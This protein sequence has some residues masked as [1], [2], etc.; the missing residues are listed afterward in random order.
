M[1][2]CVVLV[3]VVMVVVCVNTTWSWPHAKRIYKK[4]KREKR[5]NPPKRTNAL[6]FD[7]SVAL[8]VARNR[9]VASGN[10]PEVTNAHGCCDTA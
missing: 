4:T 9:S 5:K 7:F 10:H 3:L 1:C 2:N 8:L 6:R